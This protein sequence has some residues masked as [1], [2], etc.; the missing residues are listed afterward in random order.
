MYMYIIDVS[1]VRDSI[2]IIGSL[3]CF[4]SCYNKCLK[5][6]FGYRRFEILRAWRKCCLTLVYLALIQRCLIAHWFLIDVGRCMTIF[7]IQGCPKK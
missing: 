2:W 5:I 6:V 3:H 1:V 4:R 7:F